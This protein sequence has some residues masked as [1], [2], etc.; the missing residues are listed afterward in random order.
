MQAW[1]AYLV[2][3]HIIAKLPPIETLSLDNVCPNIILDSFGPPRRLIIRF[4]TIPPSDRFSEGGC[5]GWVRLGARALGVGVEVTFVK[6]PAPCALLAREA[7]DWLYRENGL[8]IN[9]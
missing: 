1:R 2:V 5:K 6:P 4:S 9:D 8:A 3:L 7:A